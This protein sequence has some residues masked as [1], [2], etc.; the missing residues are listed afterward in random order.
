[1]T[2][3][4]ELHLPPDDLDGR[5]ATIQKVLSAVGQEHGV[6][7]YVNGLLRHFDSEGV[8]A[9]IAPARVAQ[10]LH[11]GAIYRCITGIR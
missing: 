6:Y 1:M 3:F 10:A 5:R 2:I 8:L 4:Q 7:Y 11:A 9:L